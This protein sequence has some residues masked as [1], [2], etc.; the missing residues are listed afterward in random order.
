MEDRVA[1]IAT[2]LTE[3]EAAH[4]AYEA[5]DLGGEYDTAWPRWYAQYLVDHG[6]AEHLGWNLT[7]EDL[8]R[9]LAAGWSEYDASSRPDAEPWTIVMARR[10]GGDRPDEPGE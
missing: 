7:A 6:V 1:R 8:S 5:T 4:G 9:K 2:L 10:L 3:A